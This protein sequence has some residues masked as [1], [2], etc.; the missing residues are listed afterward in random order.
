MSKLIMACF[1]LAVCV[2]LST[3]GVSG[4]LLNEYEDCLELAAE[5][6]DDDSVCDPFVDTTVYG[7]TEAALEGGQNAPLSQSTVIDRTD[8]DPRLCAAIQAQWLCDYAGCSW[9]GN[10]FNNCF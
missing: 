2:V 3:I 1:G 10:G 6:G 7:T 9:Q 4:C 5:H 8:P